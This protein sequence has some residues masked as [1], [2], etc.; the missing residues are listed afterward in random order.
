MTR[1]DP[2]PTDLAAA[3]AM[4]LAQR[5]MLAEA[6]SEAKVWA[7]EIERLKL[8]LAKARRE[9]FGQSSERGRQLIEQLEL[10]IADL[11]EARAEEE[12]K[13]EIAAPEKQREKRERT[14][15]KPARRTLP[16]NLPRERIVY[17]P[18][19]ACGKCG[20]ANLRKL[21]E[22]VTES[23]ECEPHP[24]KAVRVMSTRPACRSRPSSQTTTSAKVRWMSIPITRLTISSLP[25]EEK[26]A[27][28]LTTTTDPRSQRNRAS[29]RG[30]QLQTRAR[31]SSY[32]IGLP[33]LRAPGASIPDGRTIR[34]NHHDPSR[35]ERHRRSSYRLRILLKACSRRSGIVKSA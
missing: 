8:M 27:W 25:I 4:I 23:L 35:T 33:A 24:S 11:E 3:H 1:S 32:N 26:G 15:I 22:A 31:G 28:G 9:K 21:G 16:A 19:C 2:L 18:P 30:G 10:A 5:E 17:P 13:A 7:L 34:R 14:G 29:R 6:R 12:A 20:G